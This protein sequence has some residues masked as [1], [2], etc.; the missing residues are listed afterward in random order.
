[1]SDKALTKTTVLD[2]YYATGDFECFCFDKHD[3]PTEHDEAAAPLWKAW[4]DANERGAGEEE[5]NAIPIP[6]DCREYP[7]N[8]L[9]DGTEH[10]K[11]KWT[12]TVVFEP[13]E[14]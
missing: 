6:D 1:M 5:L 9:P 13:E 14:E 8:L 3:G 12:I 4:S 10:R 7:D 11:G 2:G